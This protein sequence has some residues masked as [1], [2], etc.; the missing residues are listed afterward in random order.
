[1]T[2]LAVTAEP[3]ANA[4]HLAHLFRGLLLANM[5]SPIIEAPRNWGHQKEVVVGLKWQGARPIPQKS[6]RNDGHWQKVRVEALNPATTLAVGVHRLDCPQPDTLTFEV[7]LGVDTRLTYEQQL[8]KSGARLYSGETR[9]RCRAALRLNCEASS[10][11]E[12]RPGTILPDMVVRVRVTQAELFYTGLVCEHTLGMGGD[13]AK[14]MGNTF[15]D[16]LLAVKPSMERDLL[17]KA[18]AAIVQAADTKEVR[19]KLDQLLKG[20]PAR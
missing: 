7:M 1:L 14:W 19:V 15:H 13:A 17:A 4:E 3:S 6:L 12:H 18:N 16:L 10:R 11:L 20:L 5:P 9:A 2:T 8:W